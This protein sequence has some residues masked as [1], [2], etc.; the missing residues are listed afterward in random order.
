MPLTEQAI[1]T[2]AP[3]KAIRA[4]MRPLDSPVSHGGVE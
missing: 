1:A 2:S 4:A 3:V